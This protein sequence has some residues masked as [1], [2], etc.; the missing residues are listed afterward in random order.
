MAGVEVAAEYVENE[1]TLRVVKE[2]G[3]DYAQ[4]YV[5]GRPTHIEL[6]TPLAEEPIVVH[7]APPAKDRRK[8][9]TR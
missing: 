7:D 4:G 2:L 9:G 8:K 1:E 5:I 3:I 6:G